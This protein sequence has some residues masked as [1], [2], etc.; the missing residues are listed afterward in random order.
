MSRLKNIQNNC[1]HATFLI[2]KKH[3][4]GL[5][6]RE[7]VELRIHLTGCSM[8]RLFNKQSR[9]INEMVKQLFRRS[10]ETRLDDAY[11]QRLQNLIDDELNKN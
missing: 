7:T 4:D 5:T 8:C 10:A 3:T 6:F 1:K 9:Q 2:E 11:K